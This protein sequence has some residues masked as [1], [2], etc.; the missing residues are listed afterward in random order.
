M[1][2]ARFPGGC[3][4]VL[5]LFIASHLTLCGCNDNSRT[6]GTQVEVSDKVLAHRKARA[7]SYKG[8][9]PNSKVKAASKKR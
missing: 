5:V 6:S 4:L 3:I 2:R 7:E 1:T 8:G 9:P